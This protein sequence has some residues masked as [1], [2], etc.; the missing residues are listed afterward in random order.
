MSFEEINIRQAAGNAVKMIN[1]DWALVTAGDR[2]KWNTMTVSWGGLG[3]L[4]RRD[5]AFIFIR[6]QRYTREFIEKQEL[7]TVS[8][9]AGGFKK[10]LALCGAKSGRDI[11]K[12]A[13]TGL[14][15]VFEDGAV[16]FEQA[17]LV[18]VCRKI[19]FQDINPA[20]FLDE[21]IEENYPSKD[22]HRMY[23]GEITKTY[24]KTD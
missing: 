24:R 15:P 13:A 2:E 3:E 21:T 9:F 12:A 20:G 10:E 22:Y 11:D 7:F 23:V 5:A 17:N 14:V 6:P 4:W 16:F 18:L 1:D 19:A 8:F